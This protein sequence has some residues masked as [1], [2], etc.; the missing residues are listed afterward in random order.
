MS[1][2]RSVAPVMRNVWW[3]LASVLA[4]EAVQALSGLGPEKTG[5]YPINP[6]QLLLLFVMP[7]LTAF[8]FVRLFLACV[9]SCYG[10][11]NTYTLTSSPFAWV[12]WL[13]LAV[14][15][16]GQGEHAASAALRAVLPSVVAHGD[17]AATVAFFERQ[18]GLWL[19][20]LGF[21]SMTGVVLLLGPGS[22]QRAYGAD[23][24]LLGLGSVATFGFAIVY[25]GVEGRQIVLAVLGSGMLAAIGLWA[26]PGGERTH[27]PVGLLVLPGTLVAGLG[28]LVWGLIVGGQPTW[29]F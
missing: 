20:G 23:R 18:L 9:Q 2:A 25:F 5:S 26:V 7:G 17:Y 4:W 3:L 11:L 1:T 10:S 16:V 28:L 29:P 12:F 22:P 24:L 21:L 27:D 14:A 15:M 6:Y 19:L 8:A 13:G